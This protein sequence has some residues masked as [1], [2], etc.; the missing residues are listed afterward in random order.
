LAG[1]TGKYRIA[2]SLNMI[3]FKAFADPKVLMPHSVDESDSIFLFMTIAK[4]GDVPA[5]ELALY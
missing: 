1:L 2:L 3:P 5:I 4:C